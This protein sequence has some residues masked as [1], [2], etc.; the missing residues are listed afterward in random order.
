[1]PA[2]PPVSDSTSTQTIRALS[3]PQSSCLIPISRPQPPRPD[4][5][6]GAPRL[7]PEACR[8]NLSGNV[9]A[10]IQ[11]FYEGNVQGVG[12]RYTAK[13]IAKGFDITGSVRNLRDGSVEL[14]ATGQEGEVR[15]FLEAIARSELRAHIKKHSETPL[16]NPPD[17]RGF[18]IRHD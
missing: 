2:A 7:P 14:Q 3:R 10:S 9:I 6:T 12:F 8:I 11:V 16:P 13:Q 15:A 17:F 4:N 18:E 5:K 1:M